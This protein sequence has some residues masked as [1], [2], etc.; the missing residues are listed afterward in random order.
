MIPNRDEVRNEVSSIKI[1]ISLLVFG[2]LAVILSLIK[3]Y[4]D[5]D[6]SWFGR[7]GS[8]LVFCCAVVE[9]RCYGAEIKIL[10]AFKKAAD[11]IGG[12]SGNWEVPDTR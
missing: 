7:S 9:T 5:C 10:S 12:A 3:S 6:A 8:I 11:Y 4:I 2:V 1:E